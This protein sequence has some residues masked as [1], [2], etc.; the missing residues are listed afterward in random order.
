MYH[1]LSGYTAKVAGTER[2]LGAAPE[3]VFSACFGAPFMTLPPRRYADM[4]GEKMRRHRSGAWLLNTGWIGGPPGAGRRINL[5][6]SR[7]LVEAILE[8]ALHEVPYRT[9]SFFGLD[10]PTTCPNFPDEIL[11]P[12]VSWPD[13]ESYDRQAR[14]LARRFHENFARFSGLGDGIRRAGPRL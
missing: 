2:G 9:D 11:D 7:A 12:S 3:A 10:I 5:G 13:A 14:N 6:H 1:F 4:L 8:G